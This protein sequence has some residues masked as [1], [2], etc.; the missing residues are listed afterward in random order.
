MRNSKTQEH[1]H[2]GIEHA[3]KISAW[4]ER[5]EIVTLGNVMLDS[6]K[7][8]PTEKCFENENISNWVKYEREFLN[9]TILRKDQEHHGK[10]T[11]DT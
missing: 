3:E 5:E 1:V 10:D 4:L 2:Q 8:Q 7:Y 6:A 11:E 9:N